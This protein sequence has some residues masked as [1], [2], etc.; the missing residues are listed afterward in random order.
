MIDEMT[1]HFAVMGDKKSEPGSPVDLNGPN[2]IVWVDGEQTPLEVIPY[3]QAIADSF[4]GKVVLVHVIE[5][6]PNQKSPLDPVDWE[7]RRH[8]AKI[9][10]AELAQRFEGPGQG[11]EIR[12]LE[13]RCVDQIRTLVARRP[14]DIITV[15]RNLDDIDWQKAR[16]LL[17]SD[18][19]S[20]LL[21]PTGLVTK[22][23]QAYS[24][25]FVPLDGSSLAESAVP[26]ATAIAR[27]HHAE[28][29]ICL[30]TPEP[31]IARIGPVE[32]EILS[33]GDEMKRRNLRVAQN[34]VD[35]VKRRIDDCGL[36]ATAIVMEGG[37]VRRTLMDAASQHA[38]DLLVI[39]SH[40]QSASMDVSSGHVA[41]FILH[42]TK[43]PVLMIR[44]QHKSANEHIFSDVT[45]EG[46]RHPA[47]G[48]R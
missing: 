48:G 6:P 8:E 19:G 20:V 43:I 47:E 2:I 42:H 24:R 35:R 40:G 13:G 33:L 36:S 15:S 12:I 32:G 29:I 18:V 34:Y 39:A 5:P 41:S 44:Q 1:K 22:P 4:G 7:M 38:A 31:G 46:V 17:E 45:S 3:A 28:L 27:L 10:L 16:C 26:K 21:V 11:I 25:I 9:R 30:V 23:K 14:Q 37:D